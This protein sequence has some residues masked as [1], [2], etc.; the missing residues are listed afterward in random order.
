MKKV[1]IIAGIVVGVL[2]I[3]GLTAYGVFKSRYRTM[4]ENTETAFQ[5]MGA[6]DP[7]TLADGT[8]RGSFG[9]FLASVDLEVTV[10]D[11]RIDAITITDQK[12]GKGYE[13]RETVDRIIAAQSP[14][15]DAVSGATGSSKCI[16]IAAHRA[17]AKAR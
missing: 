3:A 15:V 1:G 9:E 4:V 17:L 5:A 14:R 8:Y 11:G 13:A 7:A 16:M 6:T 2:L 10:K 12:C